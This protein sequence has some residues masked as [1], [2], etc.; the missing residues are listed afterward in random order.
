MNRCFVLKAGGGGGEEKAALVC[1]GVATALL[2]GAPQ[3]RLG[4]GARRGVQPPG[5]QAL[6]GSL[7]LSP[8]PASRKLTGSPLNRALQSPGLRRQ[9]SSSILITQP[10]RWGGEGEEKGGEGGR[11]GLS[12][13]R[14]RAA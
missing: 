12:W 6:P 11:G 9:P 10:R 2:E 3:G 4:A 13:W 5:P 8:S 7:G 1:F 14:G